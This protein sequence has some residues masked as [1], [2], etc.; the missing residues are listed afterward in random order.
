VGFLL[1]NRCYLSLF[2]ELLAF[3]SCL[4]IGFCDKARRALL[5]SNLKRSWNNPF[6]VLFCAQ[7]I[8]WK[9]T[10]SKFLMVLCLE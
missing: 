2:W 7:T 8:F 4:P 10:F 6:Y 9:S 5:H 1:K 3:Y